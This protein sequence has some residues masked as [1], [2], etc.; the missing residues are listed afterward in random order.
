MKLSLFIKRRSEPEVDNKATFCTKFTQTNNSNFE[1]LPKKP[2]TF[3][4]KWK[5]L[6]TFCCYKCKTKNKTENLSKSKKLS[7]SNNFSVKNN[8]AKSINDKNVD[9]KITKEKQIFSL[10]SSLSQEIPSSKDIFSSQSKVKLELCDENLRESN[11]KESKKKKS[12]EMNK[13]NDSFTKNNKNNIQSKFNLKDVENNQ[14]QTNNSTKVI[15]DILPENLIKYMRAV[16]EQ[17]K[18][19]L[20]IKSKNASLENVDYYAPLAKQESIND[21]TINLEDFYFEDSIHINSKKNFSL[22]NSVNKKDNASFNRI[23]LNANLPFSEPLKNKRTST[24]RQGLNPYNRNISNEN[25][26]SNDATTT[27][28]SSIYSFT[29]SSINIQNVKDLA[30]NFESSCYFTFNKTKSDLKIDLYSNQNNITST[31]NFTSLEKLELIKPQSKDY[32]LCFDTSSII[33]NNSSSSSSNDLNDLNNNNGNIFNDFSFPSSSTNEILDK[34]NTS[35]CENID[36]IKEKLV[37]DSGVDTART[38]SPQ[39]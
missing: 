25:F 37:Y 6:S 15:Q 26:R 14:R 30:S 22:R 20:S 3:K 12:K 19:E 7:G 1:A 38:L 5:I 13:S 35:F 18:T 23:K 34:F 2:N 21:V 28:N 31:T 11:K 39:I 27:S 4:S 24:P 17:S 36:S 8:E 33:D 9:K 16:L 29:S 10:S 32:I